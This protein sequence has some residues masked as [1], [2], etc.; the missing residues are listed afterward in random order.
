MFPFVRATLFSNFFSTYLLPN[1]TNNLIFIITALSLV[2]KL[3]FLLAT[4]SPRNNRKTINRSQWGKLHET[5]LRPSRHICSRVSYKWEKRFISK[6]KLLKFIAA[7]SGRIR[8]SFQIKEILIDLYNLE[9]LSKAHYIE[10]VIHALRDGS[11]ENPNHIVKVFLIQRPP[12]GQCTRQ[13]TSCNFL[14]FLGSPMLKLRIF[15]FIQPIPKLFKRLF[16]PQ[17]S[18]F[19]LLADGTVTEIFDENCEETLL[20]DKITLYRVR[21]QYFEMLWSKY[22]QINGWKRF[23]LWFLQRSLNI[24]N[25][26]IWDVKPRIKC[27]NKILKFYLTHIPTCFYTSYLSGS[28]FNFNCVHET[29]W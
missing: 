29:C 14:S 11:I 4:F 5:F 27:C 24:C 3:I 22:L 23:A 6:T 25:A 13:Q 18:L 10:D 2:Q 7:L 28:S 9:R 1:T 15:I 19:F 12:F 16:V 8:L 20:R 26:M 21:Q 17:F